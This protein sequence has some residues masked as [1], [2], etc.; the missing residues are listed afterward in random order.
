MRSLSSFREVSSS[1]G[2][3]TP[4]RK[5]MPNV[6]RRITLN[7][8]AFLWLANVHYSAMSNLRK[9]LLAA[10]FGILVLAVAIV[11][12]SPAAQPVYKGQPLDYWLQI[13]YTR[14]SA[15]AEPAI[16]YMGTNTLPFLL[17]D[18][19]YE[20]SPLIES[21]SRLGSK[22]PFLHIPPPRYIPDERN[23]AA[24]FAFMWLGTNSAPAVPQLIKMYDSHPNASWSSYVPLA[25]GF[26]GPPAKQAVPM[27]L[28]ALTKTNSM[29][30]LYAAKALGQIHA[31]APESV[32]ALVH[33]LRDPQED[34]RM[35]AVWALH[36]FGPG[37]KKAVPDLLQFVRDEKHGAKPMS[38]G[39]F[40]LQIIF[41]VNIY[42]V[43]REAVWN[44]DPDAA[45][46]ANFDPY[47]GHPK[48]RR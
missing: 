46:K 23:Y 30:R 41:T 32:T 2:D 27:L 28:S 17:R 34:V 44:L 36:E 39:K 13:I 6:W 16:R 12:L 5:L 31:D 19:Q 7:K 42:D 10:G 8:S 9:T 14:S 11:A 33:C 40:P 15:E 3:V 26:V 4:Q 21:V 48:P 18:L 20:K 25:V 24:T 43:A 45:R 22:I 29:V 38:I 47:P 35:S 1:D 37:A